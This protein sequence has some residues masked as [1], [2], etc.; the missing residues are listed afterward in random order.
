MRRLGKGLGYLVWIVGNLFILGVAASQEAFAPGVPVF[1][2]IM[3]L[4]FF[5]VVIHELGHAW[6][7]HRR[8]AH[9]LRIVALPFGYDTATNT[10]GIERDV[11]RSDIGG[12]VSYVYRRRDETRRDHIA[13]A[14]AGP[15]ANLASALLVVA[16]I[17]GFQAMQKEPPLQRP[18]IEA[19][20]NLGGPIARLPSDE[21]MAA[22]LEY[23]EERRNTKWRTRL[24]TGLGWLFAA[25]SAV[26]GIANLV[27]TRG[28]DGSVILRNL[29]PSRRRA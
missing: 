2:T 4:N 25:I 18:A 17:I 9:V 22:I 10:L 28:S 23:E 11:P 21:E 5:A 26:L 27:P 20:T 12:Y 1:L 19:E 16:A 29:A 3:L 6:V 8:G 14:A 7:A 24:A 15:L 13:I